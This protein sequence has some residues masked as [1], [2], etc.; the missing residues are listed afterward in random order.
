MYPPNSGNSTP[1]GS[2]SRNFTSREA[3]FTDGIAPGWKVRS[4]PHYYSKRTT[5]VIVKTIVGIIYW[6]SNKLNVFFYLES[7]AEILSEM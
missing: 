7:P 3:G 5:S 6:V 4:S 2:F 1:S